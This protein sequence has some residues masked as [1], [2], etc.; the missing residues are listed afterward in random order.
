M[1][2]CAAPAPHCT[3]AAAAISISPAHGKIAVGRG[4]GAVPL[5]C[6]ICH[7]MTVDAVVDASTSMVPVDF[8][9]VSRRRVVRRLCRSVCARAYRAPC[10]VPRCACCVLSCGR[11]GRYHWVHCTC[12]T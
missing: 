11:A 5:P 3:I 9:S 6:P 8:V 7:E 1:R 2:A 12:S 10:V 4:R